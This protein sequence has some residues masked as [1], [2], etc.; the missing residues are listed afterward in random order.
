MIDSV[1]HNQEQKHFLRMPSTQ[2]MWWERD[3]HTSH[4]FVSHILLQ[5]Q[6][7]SKQWGS[8]PTKWFKKRPVSNIQFCD[9]NCFV[10]FFPGREK[11]TAYRHLFSL[12]FVSKRLIKHLFLLYRRL[13]KFPPGTTKVQNTWN[14]YV[15]YFCCASKKYISCHF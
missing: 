5:S 10:I 14:F 15:N 6:E 13:I 8:C 11:R 9:T 12:E 7:L 1:C 4:T 2:C 3:R